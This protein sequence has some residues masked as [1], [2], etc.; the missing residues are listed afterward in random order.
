MSE[1]GLQLADLVDVELQLLRDRDA[2]REDVRR[3][4]RRIGIAIDAGKRAAS[5][6]RDERLALLR[7]WVRAVHSETG[8]DSAGGRTVRTYHALGWLLTLLG[9]SSGSGAAAAVL[10]YDGTRPVNV[11]HFLALFV[12][13]QALLL[14]LLALSTGLWRFRDRMPA[15]SGLYG[16]LRWAFDAVAGLFERR[17]SA[18]RRT[19]LKAARGRL[20]S[21]QIIYGAV[22]R[23]LLVSLA[24]RLGLAF[25]LGALATCLYL[26]AV[27]DLAFAWQTTLNVSADGFHRLLSVLAAPWS[28][29]YPDGLPALDVVRA[30][31]YFRLGSSFGQAA[32]AELLGQWWRFLVLCLLVYG[33]AP[34]LILS[35]VARAKLRRALA[36]LRLDHGEIASLLE[37]LASPIIRTQSP[38]PEVGAEAA[39]ASGTGTAPI[40]AASHATVLV[41]GDV[42]IE[43][44]QID[45]L[46]G[47][48][49][50]WRVDSIA[51]A[52]AGEARLDQAAIDAVAREEAPVVLLAE[53]FEAPT[54]EART[55]LARLREAIGRDRPIVVSLVDSDA[56]RWSPPS[57]DDLRVWQ[58]QLAQLGDP[59]LRVEA[60]VEGA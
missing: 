27:S 41:W 8:Q 51:N 38:T 28:W 48:R 26:V 46:V 45:S 32:P 19:M 12:G 9:L 7:D 24:Q 50:G 47:D 3:R 53:S 36:A 10:S 49:F 29:A 43:R 59:Y 57:P 20:R 15:V 5:S 30:S 17:M 6:D 18:E 35:L 16:L 23:W 22:E 11:V 31:R 52:G 55:F 37:R 14:L 56:G 40:A 34:R 2:G 33:L 60:L 13:V 1:S 39:T 25:N 4:D 58:K 42:P 44:A 54:R 21:S